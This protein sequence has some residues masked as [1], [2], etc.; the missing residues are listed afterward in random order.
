MGRAWMRS[1][2]AREDRQAHPTQKQQYVQRQRDWKGM[3]H[4]QQCCKVPCERGTVWSELA[5]S[6]GGAWN[7]ALRS[8]NSV[9]PVPRDHRTSLPAEKR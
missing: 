2:P 8:Q 5:A 6:L 1:S 3:W 7:S 4:A 9:L